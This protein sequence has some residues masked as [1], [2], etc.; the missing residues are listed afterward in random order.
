MADPRE[1]LTAHLLDLGII[2]AE[3]VSSIDTLV[4]LARDSSGVHLEEHDMLGMAQAL[5]RAADRAAA[6]G[7][8][9]AVRRLDHLPAAERSAAAEAWITAV[10][11]VVAATFTL[12]CERRARQISRR[13]LGAAAEGRHAEP[14]VTV[15]FVDLRGSTAFMLDRSPHEIEELTDVL[16]AVGQEAA[17]HHDVA[18]GKFLGDGVLL[19]SADTARLLA[20]AREAVAS[21]ARRTELRAGA[22]VAW[23]QVIRRA[24]DWHGPPVNLAARLAEVAAADEILVDFTAMDRHDGA[25]ATWRDI[26]PRG[27][28]EPRRVAVFTAR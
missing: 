27:V 9:I 17:T 19:V 23:G 25:S 4:A 26:V 7:A 5:G 16:Y 3:D 10:M 12:L 20:A 13:R 15:A 21:L 28:P 14:P 8:D 6:A 2:E 22:G 1:R 11:P 18:A 24:G